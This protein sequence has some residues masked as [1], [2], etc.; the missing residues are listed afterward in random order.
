MNPFLFRLMIP[1]A[2]KRSLRH[3]LSMPSKGVT[4]ISLT[5]IINGSGGIRLFG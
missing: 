3:G 1:F 4:G 5:A 2:K